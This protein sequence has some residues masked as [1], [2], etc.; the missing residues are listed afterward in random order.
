MIPFKLKL[1]MFLELEMHF[2]FI[3]SLT[4]IGEISGSY[5]SE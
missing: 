1:A 5:G 4:Q 2:Y 3:I